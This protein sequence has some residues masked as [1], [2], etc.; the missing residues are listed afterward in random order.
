[1]QYCSGNIVEN[2]T[3]IFWNNYDFDEIWNMTSCKFYSMFP[4]TGYFSLAVEDIKKVLLWEL[5]V[6]EFKL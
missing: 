4:L 3:A 1:M 2:S 5:F 6:H